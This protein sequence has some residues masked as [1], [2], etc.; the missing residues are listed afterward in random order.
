MLGAEQ[1]YELNPSRPQSRHIADSLR[2]DPGLVCHQ[3]DP[4]VADQV[5]AV[6]EQD[7]NSGMHPSP[8]GPGSGRK[9]LSPRSGRA[10]KTA[11]KQSH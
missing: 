11:S 5:Q 10:S 4:T 8:G 9:S 2:I 3:S 6:G 7:R 1:G